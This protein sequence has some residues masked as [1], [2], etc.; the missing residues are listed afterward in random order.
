MLNPETLTTPAQ[1]TMLPDVGNIYLGVEPA[2]GEQIAGASPLAGELALELMGVEE[3]EEHAN[4]TQDVFG[5]MVEQHSDQHSGPQEVFDA[6]GEKNTDIIEKAVESLPFKETAEI[7]T[8]VEGFYNDNDK[9]L[10]AVQMYVDGKASAKV[11][12]SKE[13]DSPIFSWALEDLSSRLDGTRTTEGDELSL[14]I[15]RELYSECSV[16]TMTMTDEFIANRAATLVEL[17]AKLRPGMRVD[18]VETKQNIL[19]GYREGAKRETRPAG[20]LLFHN[21][22]HLREI[23]QRGFKLSGRSGQTA[24]YGNSRSNTIRYGEGQ[25]S[26]S[27]VTHFS[28]VYDPWA[29]HMV[30]TVESASG[31]VP[32][33]SG[34]VALPIAEVVKVAPYA[35]DTKY[36]VIEAKPDSQVSFTS[37]T[38]STIVGE[39]KAGSPDLAGGGYLGLDRVFFASNKTEEIQA[40]HNYEV[41]F[42][43][44]GM[45]V[46]DTS[47]PRGYIIRTGIDAGI[48]RQDLSAANIAGFGSPSVITVETT[49]N[50]PSEAGPLVAPELLKIEAESIARYDGKFVVPLRGHQME[51][52]DEGAWSYRGRGLSGRYILRANSAS[53][54]GTSV[55]Y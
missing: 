51:F 53:H 32:S 45:E 21:T 2:H 43:R 55:R 23:M 40:A 30:Q 5:S 12:G 50:R 35:R 20:L 22:P 46:G 33:L 31:D 11:V 24:Q 17:E 8:A 4:K 38:E 49:A 28:E 26:H 41:D 54:T 48:D 1:E 39:I 25:E 52:L 42:G 10:A 29:Y 34:T 44:M 27:N 15:L 37:T 16:G 36:A 7:R 13:V 19:A 14:D 3:P 18:S 6:V 9:M 47:E